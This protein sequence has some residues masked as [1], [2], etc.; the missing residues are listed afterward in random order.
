MIQQLQK[1]GSNRIVTYLDFEFFL[2]SYFWNIDYLDYLLIYINISIVV[3]SVV[4]AITSI[5]TQKYL[6]RRSREF[7]R[8]YRTSTKSQDSKHTE[9]RSL[10]LKRVTKTYLWILFMFLV[11]YIP[12]PVC[13]YILKFCKTCSCEITYLMRD[14]SYYFIAGNSCMNPFVC[15]LKHRNYRNKLRY[16]FRR[17]NNR[18]QSDVNFGKSSLRI[19]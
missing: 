2:S 3:A 17:K 8:K 5:K 18:T 19:F 7:S 13:V 9:R 16:L 6:T 1:K 11:C 15:L 14:V 4:L 10:Q 12:A